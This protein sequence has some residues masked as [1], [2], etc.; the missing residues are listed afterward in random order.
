M[1]SLDAALQF[2]SSGGGTEDGPSLYD[3][4]VVQAPD[5]LP[6]GV[7]YPTGR[8]PLPLGPPRTFVLVK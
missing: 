5:F 4:A 2:R 1:I 6:D 8:K 3:F 7:E